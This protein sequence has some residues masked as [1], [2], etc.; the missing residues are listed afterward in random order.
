MNQACGQSIPIR[1]QSGRSPSVNEPGW[2]VNLSAPPSV[3]NSSPAADMPRPA[4][5]TAPCVRVGGP[6]PPAAA[7][8]PNA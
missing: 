8:S 7:V 1:W 6:R 2:Q 4:Q 3:L 5:T